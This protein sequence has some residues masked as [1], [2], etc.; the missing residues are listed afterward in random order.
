MDWNKT[1]AIG[2][3]VSV[4]LTCVI[5]YVTLSPK[6]PSGPTVPAT[7]VPWS[8]LVMVA[9]LVLVA[10]LNW[11]AGRL[12]REASREHV[13]SPNPPNAVHPAPPLAVRVETPPQPSQI[14]QRERVLIQKRPR[15]LIAPFEQ[16]TNY[17]AEKIVADYVGG[18]V[19][20]TVRITDVAVDSDGDAR[21][22]CTALDQGEYDHPYITA[23]F[24][25]TRAD[26]VLHLS[27]AA[28][29]DVAGTIK[30]VEAHWITLKD[31]RI[32]QD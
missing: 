7:T 8:T 23:K 10:L 17:Q 11:R 32:I 31:C 22:V 2:Q 13:S 24:P 20:W 28:Q 6:Q 1:G 30:S 19:H 3:W 21:V 29:I 26:Q 4:A 16:F 9:A 25:K 18:E 14:A 27:K 15:D 12:N 5:M